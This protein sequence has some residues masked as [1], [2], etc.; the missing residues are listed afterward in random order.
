MRE[1][2]QQHLGSRQVGRVVYGAII[3][4]ALIVAIEHHPPG[5]GVVAVWLL[6]TALAVGLAEIYSEVVG[7]ETSTRRQVTR[8]DVGPMVEDA[9]AVGFGV[10][11]PAVFFLL[12]VFGVVDVDGAFALAKWTGLGLIGFYGFWAARFAGSTPHGA[13][14]KGALVAL[15]G[16]GLILLKS[17]VH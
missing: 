11:F 16:A 1:S 10:A 13:L 3:G 2:L 12:A 17:L 8:A 14:L 15:I 6:G 9:G 5:P 4:L 7:H